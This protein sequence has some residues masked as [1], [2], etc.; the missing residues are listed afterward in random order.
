M[1]HFL[2]MCV[3][4]TFVS[5]LELIVAHLSFCFS[6]HPYMEP[7]FPLLNIKRNKQ[8]NIWVEINPASQACYDLSIFYLD[9]FPIIKHIDPST[10]NPHV[11]Q[12]IYFFLPL[13]KFIHKHGLEYLHDYLLHPSHCFHL[14]AH[15]HLYTNV[16]ILFS[17]KYLQPY[18]DIK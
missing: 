10:N 11:T 2:V 7:S 13:L 5:L 14:I 4:N 3:R 6:S 16:R 8:N 18:Y 1:Q 9:L 15:A 17:L 12:K